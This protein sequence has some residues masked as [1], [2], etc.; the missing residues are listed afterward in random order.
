MRLRDERRK[1]VVDIWK[2]IVSVQQHFND[3]EMRIR[4]IF[5]TILLALFASIGFLLDKRLFL[6]FWIIK[7]QFATLV[8]LFGILGTCLFYFMDRH[9]YHRL[10]LGSVLHGISI[11][12]KYSKE[13]PE[14][15][16]SE[17]IGRLSPFSPTGIIWLIAKI[18][19]RE[20]RFK[21]T[22]RIHSDGKIELFYKS[23]MVFLLLTSLML[24]GLGGVEIDSGAAH[25]AFNAGQIAWLWFAG[26]CYDL[27][28]SVLLA[29]A[30]LASTSHVLMA[31]SIGTFDYNIFL[32]RMF[33][34]QKIDSRFGAF[35]LGIGFV[36]QAF[37]ALGIAVQ[38]TV[39]IV[40]LFVPLVGAFVLY[41]VKRSAL[42]KN[43]MRAALQS[44]KTLHGQSNLDIEHEIGRAYEKV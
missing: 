24:A 33:S 35:F 23:V 8:P 2:T 17:E 29:R 40:L 22:G 12:K 3:I 37:S 19:V 5:V 25:M 1:E 27:I 18:V 34:E 21:E 4:S 7:V 44:F 11:E 16:L 6:Q 14:L 41:A 9:W 36:L 32:L 38:N 10:L 31:Q 15:S 26:A 13:I 30:L 28:G 39:V 43:Q 42:T 20:Q